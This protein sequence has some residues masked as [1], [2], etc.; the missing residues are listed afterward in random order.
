MTP[1][2][3]I[4]AGAPRGGFGPD[5]TSHVVSHAMTMV[6]PVYM[7][8]PGQVD[9]IDAFCRSELGCSDGGELGSG[10]CTGALIDGLNVP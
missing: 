1:L 3:I 4:H 7:V 5:V 10:T 6:L 9:R 8:L 2:C